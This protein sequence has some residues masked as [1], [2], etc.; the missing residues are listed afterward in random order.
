MKHL[1]T[2][3]IF[4]SQ[5]LTKDQK[6][7]L[8]DHVAGVWSLNR[9]GR[10]DID[11]SFW[12]GGAGL[13]DFKGIQFGEV[14]EDFF[15][16]NNDLTSLKGS[17]I[18]VLGKFKCYENRITSLEG[19]PNEVTGE[20]DCRPSDYLI[21][22]AGAPEVGGFFTGPANIVISWG[23]WTP[24]GIF[25]AWLKNKNKR[26][27]DLL[28]TLMSTHVGRDFFQEKIDADPSQALADLKNYFSE[29]WFRAM[30]L[31]WPG[32]MGPWV[33]LMGDAGELGF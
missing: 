11:G 13:K 25:E 6:E 8:N 21:S 22:L 9:E 19:G 17:P 3:A 18:K 23:E 10:V 2:F 15:C 31:K 20:Y 16:Q 12:G 7:F 28:S 24:E 1:R 26:G 30:D 27:K 4:E 32:K 33:D 5:G 29:P 14:S